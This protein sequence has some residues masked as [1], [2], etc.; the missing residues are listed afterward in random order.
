MTVNDIVL[1]TVVGSVYEQ[2]IQLTRTYR[3]SVAGSGSDVAACQSFANKLAAEVAGLIPEYTDCL[4]DQYQTSYVQVQKIFP[5]RAALR[6]AVVAQAGKRNAGPGLNQTAAGITLETDKAGRS[7]QSK[8]HIGPLDGG[9]AFNGSV[10]PDLK[11]L[12]TNLAQTFL[13]TQVVTAGVTGSYVPTIFHKPKTGVAGSWDDLTGYN[14]HD[15]LRTMRRR[16]L[17][18]GK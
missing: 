7:Q 13:L 8:M 16:V 11:A 10:S 3:C 4:S 1:V 15:E 2:M 17:G 18:R 6:F 12:L 14:V 5:V 9:D